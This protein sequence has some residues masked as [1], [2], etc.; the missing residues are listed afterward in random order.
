MADWSEWIGRESLTEAYLD[1]AQSQR[2]QATLD[3]DPNLTAGDELPPAWHWLYFHEVVPARDLGSDGHTRLG[4]T[5]PPFPL[6]RR[7]WAGGVLEWLHPVVL[8]QPAQ[9]TSRIASIQEK[10]GRSGALIFTTVEH[11]VHQAD[12]TCI[13]EEQHIVYREAATQSVASTPPPAPQDSDF[14]HR[15]QFDE[16]A[17]FRYSA[18]TFNG[19]QI[20]RAHV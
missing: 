6:P 10:Q 13:R 5:M 19:H 7:M 18:L 11:Q 14:S 16:T 20:G 9:R 4:V 8:G 15:W 17:L 12:R 1:P 2:M 3:R